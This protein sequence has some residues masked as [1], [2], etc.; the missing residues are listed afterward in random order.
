MSYPHRYVADLPPDADRVG[1]SEVLAHYFGADEDLVANFEDD[2][3]VLEA[4]WDLREEVQ[5]VI[6]RFRCFLREDF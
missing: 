1:I 3:L 5:P 4:E 6:R 2:Q